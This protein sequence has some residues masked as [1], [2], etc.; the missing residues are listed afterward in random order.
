MCARLDDF[1]GRPNYIRNHVSRY[2]PMTQP[3][4]MFGRLIATF[5][6]I[7]HNA[8]M[9]IIYNHLTSV[10]S[11]FI[12]RKL[13]QITYYRREARSATCRFC[14]YSRVDFGDFRPAEATRCT[15]QGEIWRPLHSANFHLDRLRGV[16]LRPHKR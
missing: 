6:N 1:A 11:S 15:D 3:N 13:V 14:F 16:G 8:R 10:N 4:V 5:T 12:F 7:L 9:Q 2:A